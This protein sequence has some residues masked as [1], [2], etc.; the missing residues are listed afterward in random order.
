MEPH[1]TLALWEDGSLIVYDSNQGAPMARD[2]VAEV[3]ELPPERVRVISRHVGGGFGSK[4]TPRPQMILAAMAAR[5]V[6][7]PVKV[8]VT[9]QQMF[10]VVGY[11]TPTIQRLRLGASA[12]G[13]LTAISHEVVEQTS[14]VREFAEQTAVCTRVMYAAPN[15]RTGH[16]VAQ[17]DVPTPSWMRAPGE[18][19]G[20]FALESAMDE[21]AVAA[22]LDPVQ[23]RIRNEPDVEPESGKQWSTRGLV[24]CLRE[25]AERFGW[26]E[27]DPEPALRREGRWLVGT[28]VASSTYPARRRPAQALAS[29]RPAGGATESDAADANYL[30]QI[31]AADIG[32]GARTVLTQIAADALEVE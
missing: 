5:M 11:R 20:M 16:R 18:C 28:G 6:E 2:T 3:F 29:V 10:A 24:A 32:T 27:R 26:A 19:P 17:L 9:R 8:A 1:A 21:L 31:A 25:G 22:G 4:G 7:R 14:T 15:R 30:V 13:R 12:D 23:L